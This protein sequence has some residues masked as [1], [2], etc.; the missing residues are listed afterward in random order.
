MLEPGRCAAH[1]NISLQKSYKAKDM[2]KQWIGGR[3]ES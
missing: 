2:E 3:L 1:Q